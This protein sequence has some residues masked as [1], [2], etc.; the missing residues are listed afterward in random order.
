[1]TSF[2]KLKDDVKIAF[3]SRNL[4]DTLMTILVGQ[5]FISRVINIVSI[6]YIDNA[7][8]AGITGILNLNLDILR[9]LV[10]FYVYFMFQ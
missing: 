8:R 1:M 2:N 4:N 7:N 5:C 3:S 9:A 10:S 6:Y